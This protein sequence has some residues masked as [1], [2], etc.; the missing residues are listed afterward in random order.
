MQGLDA[1]EPVQ[2]RDLKQVFGYPIDLLDDF[3]RLV[4]QNFMQLKYQHV[5][6]GV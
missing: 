2:L 5:R 4:V 3:L 6:E 1:F